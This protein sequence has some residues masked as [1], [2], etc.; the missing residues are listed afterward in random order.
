MLVF[1]ITENSTMKKLIGIFALL[2]ICLV[3]TSCL[4]DTVTVQF[5]DGTYLEMDKS[6][7]VYNMLGDTVLLEKYDGKFEHSVDRLPLRD[8]VLQHRLY[9]IYYTGD[10]LDTVIATEYRVAVLKKYGS[11]YP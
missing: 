11:Q 5:Q 1:H 7:F 9:A 2:T 4:R 3:M 10:T 6:M 8:T